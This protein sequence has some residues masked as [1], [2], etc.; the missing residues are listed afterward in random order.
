[1]VIV[2][3]ALAN[4]NNGNWQTARRWQRLLARNSAVR[5]VKQ[6]PDGVAD[7]DDVMLALHARRSWASIAAWFGARGNRGLAVVLTGTDLYRDIREDASAQESLRFARRLVLLQER[8]L[9][10]L[11]E[12]WR[13][14]ASVIHPSAPSRRTLTR[15]R[16][17]LRAVMAGHLRE[18][19]SPDTLFAA[20][21]LLAGHPDIRVDHIGKGLDTNLES[22]AL[23]T[24]AACPNYRWLGAL[25]HQATR[26]RIQRAHV[27]IHCSRMEG[28]AHVIMEAV[29]SGTP[30]LA[31]LVDGNVGMLGEDYAGYF[32]W[33]DA[34]ALAD[35]VLACR[36][37]Q[38]Q[39]DGLLSRLAAQAS[40][41]TPLFAPETERTALL[42][43]VEELSS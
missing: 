27:L 15:S 37:T 33:G 11:P 42:R 21:P 24:M 14:K 30:V 26:S 34:R 35:L 5:I 16:R 18:E 25:T 43:L 23:A 32:P 22:Q 38:D 8:G 36:A 3:P 31:S 1:M 40:L 9:L 41:R 28:G 7:Q 2:S 17:L 12:E 10:A 29:K 20:M 39:P 6:W 4:A 13:R 19:K